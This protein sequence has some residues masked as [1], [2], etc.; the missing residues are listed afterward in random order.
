V[1]LSV[2]VDVGGTFTDVVAFDGESISGRKLPT[3]ANQAVAVA[4]ASRDAGVGAE[5]TFLHGTTAGTNALLE[6]RG[7]VTALVTSPG[8]EDLIEIGRQS[9]PSLYD[10]FV[11]RPPALAP[12]S[13]RIGYDDD[14]D[15]LRARLGKA[16]AVAVAL[17]RSYLDPTQE[18]ELAERLSAELEIPVSVGAV[19]SPAFREYERIATTVLNAYLTPEVAGYLARL[20]IEVPAGKRLVMTSSGGLLPFASA[21]GYAGRLVLSGPA[22][23]VVAARAMGS[24]KGQA[25]VISFD[26]G[27]TSTDVCRID[28]QAGGGGRHGSAGWVN[29]VPSLPV[30]TIGA[31]GGSLAWVDEGGALRVG[32]RSAGAHPGPAAYG[33]GGNLATVTDAN[34]VLGRIPPDTA[35]GGSVALDVT[36]ASTALSGLGAPLS[37]GAEA[38]AAGIIEVVDTHMER[39]LRAVSVEEGVDPRDSALVAFGGAGALHATRLARR[40]GIRTTFIP[41]LSGVFSALGLLLAAPSSDAERTVMLEEGS[42]RLGSV[43]RGIFDEARATFMDHHGVTGDELTGWADLRYVGQSHELSVPLSSSW[44][45][46]RAEFE[47]AHR[48]RFGFVRSA[49][50]IELVTVRAVM[51]GHPPLS[52]DDLPRLHRTETPTASRSTAMVGDRAV[53]VPVWARA[54]LPSGF[55]TQGPAIVVERDSAVWLEPDDSLSVHEDGTLEV[56]W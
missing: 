14:L 21:A 47:T 44:D 39:A 1:T 13:L 12:R 6:G 36:A 55:E 56:V 16:E 32:P 49:E 54:E 18:Q 35:L 41:P 52:W 10:S 31:G 3:T 8:F 17:V 26:M 42:A 2:G 20:D 9:R 15:A 34:V 33:L 46:L 37:M 38:L 4:Q 28:G 29:R 45:E 7:A 24:A 51:S 19:V 5:T 27:G 53:D 23:G 11:D 40:L 25:S 30:R 50:P 48:A 22:A 43:A